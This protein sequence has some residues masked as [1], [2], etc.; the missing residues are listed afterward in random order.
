MLLTSPTYGVRASF[1]SLETITIDYHDPRAPDPSIE[2]ENPSRGETWTM[3]CIYL[4]Q[5]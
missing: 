5:K 3:A 1:D 4:E 2:A